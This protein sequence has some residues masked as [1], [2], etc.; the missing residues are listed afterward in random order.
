MLVMISE[1][2]V[3]FYRFWHGYLHLPG[4]G[5]LL[6]FCAPWL[7]PLREYPTQVPGIGTLQLNFQMDY[8]SA[9]TNFLL[10][11]HHA[12]EGLLAILRSRFSA[13][14]VFW[15]VGANIGLI[16]A[17]ML[18]SFPSATLCLFEPNPDLA[19]RLNQLF[20][21]KPNVFVNEM[22]L[23][24]R[25]SRAGF[26]LVPGHTTTGS[27][28]SSSDRDAFGIE[29][30]LQTGDH[31]LSAHPEKIPN[32]IKIDVEGHEIEV[33][34]GCRNLIAAH[35][36]VIVFE[37]IF[38]ENDS[39]AGLVPPGYEIFY[40]HDTDGRLS[41]VLDRTCSHNAILLPA[42]K[43]NRNQRSDTV[44]ATGGSVLAP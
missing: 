39:L 41:P 34:E 8:A 6:R 27:L 17:S 21:S 40:I 11:E 31:Y 37:H 26:N 36:P 28:S 5:A 19:A 14:M 1:A 9:W 32:L 16:S 4:S 2:L 29:V 33:L 44:A 20:S 23:S 7:R 25:N 22:G 15:D 12:E 3:A 38:M 10:G 18:L 24:N 30:E 13:G 42:G 35:G 43:E